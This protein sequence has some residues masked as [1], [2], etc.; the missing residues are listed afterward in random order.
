MAMPLGEGVMSDIRSRLEAL[1]EAFN[2]HDLDAIMAYFAD[3]CALRPR[4]AG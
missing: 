4:A 2:A 1:C 3:D